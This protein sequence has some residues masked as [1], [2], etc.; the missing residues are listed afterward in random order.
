MPG[1]RSRR[2]TRA[3]VLPRRPRRHRFSIA[4]ASWA[5]RLAA[6]TQQARQWE[7]RGF[8]FTPDGV[9]RRKAASVRTA[10]MAALARGDL[11]ALNAPALRRS[12]GAAPS[13]S[14]MAVGGVLRIPVILV[15]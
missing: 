13:G 10:R 3:S 4:A 1:D 11:A 15:Q 9:W 2:G 12:P 14:A 6:Q 8:D 7:P 5:G